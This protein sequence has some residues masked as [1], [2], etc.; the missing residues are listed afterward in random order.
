MKT[1]LAPN[2]FK[3]CVG[4]I[5]FLPLW[6]FGQTPPRA[7]KPPQAENLMRLEEARIKWRNTLDQLRDEA[8]KLD[9][10][11]RPSALA[12]LADAY[13]ET[14]QEKASAIF[15]TAFD[16]ALALSEEKLNALG[17]R[18]V[19]ARATR[20]SS[21][22]G[23]K[24]ITQLIEREKNGAPTQDKFGAATE[25]L[26]DDPE[27]A[28]QLVMA[29]AA[30]GPGGDVSW[31]ILSLVEKDKALADQVCLVYLNA[32]PTSRRPFLHHLIGLAGYAFGYGET[33][34]GNPDPDKMSGG[35]GMRRKNLSLNQ[36]LAARFLDLALA[37]AQ[38]T[39]AQAETAPPAEAELHN[40]IVFFTASY[41]LPEAKLYR[42]AREAAWLALQQRA[43][44]GT[45]PA[46]QT[47]TARKL[48]E[49]LR[50]RANVSNP[51]DEVAGE[52][53]Q[54]DLDDAGKT[55]GGCERDRLY[56]KAAFRFNYL[57]DPRRAFAA[58]EKIEDLKMENVKSK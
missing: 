33:I 56:A 14:D 28:A 31:F 45:S 52:M 7:E 36:A 58:A 42:P 53:A 50:Q 6:L 3:L 41:L 10:T 38:Q 11:E 21:E 51:V 2:G 35:M 5:L 22:L 54:K 29:G 37:S 30:N 27:R 47:A 46:H 26:Y 32:F 48:Q 16:S 9:E 49:A 12:D 25:L 20:R 24:F 39:L 44:A 23:R 55:A 13:W 40:T 8:R 17:R 4:F 18:Y 34:G 43:A 1:W 19:L 15:Q 57:K